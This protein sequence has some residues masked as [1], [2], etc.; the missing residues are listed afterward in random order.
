MTVSEAKKHLEQLEK[1]GRGNDAL[2]RYDMESGEYCGI[3]F[4]LNTDHDID[5]IEVMD[6]KD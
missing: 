3:K 4:I 2:M 6:V 1:D 5:V